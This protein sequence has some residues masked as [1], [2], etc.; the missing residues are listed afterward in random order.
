VISRGSQCPRTVLTHWAIV[1]RPPGWPSCGL[2][3]NSYVPHPGSRHLRTGREDA[4]PRRADAGSVLNLF[5]TLTLRSEGTSAWMVHTHKW[6]AGGC[7]LPMV[8]ESCPREPASRPIR[9]AGTSGRPLTGRGRQGPAPAPR[10]ALPRPARFSSRSRDSRFAVQAPRRSRL[11]AAYRTQA[12]IPIGAR[13][14]VAELAWL[15]P[16][17]RRSRR[18]AGKLEVVWL[19]GCLPTSDAA[20]NLRGG[21]T[22]A[23]AK[24]AGSKSYRSVPL[25]RSSHRRCSHFPGL[26][27][28]CGTAGRFAY[29]SVAWDRLNGTASRWSADSPPV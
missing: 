1:C 3:P 16:G 19:G 4:R 26:D 21:A 12:A 20:D 13:A 22:L 15:A 14:A 25:C 18:P 17:P 11:P 2:T 5:R 9:Q 8:N 27:R 10:Q 24:I 6:N 7:D 28:I 29:C 23:D